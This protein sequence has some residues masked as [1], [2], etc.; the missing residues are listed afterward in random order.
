[1]PKA[2]FSFY[3][4]VGSKKDMVWKYR[5]GKD[6]HTNLT[7]EQFGP[8]HRDLHADHVVEIQVRVLVRVNVAHLLLV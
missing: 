5:K 4:D 6:I 3:V 7:K 2:R 1:M 8:F